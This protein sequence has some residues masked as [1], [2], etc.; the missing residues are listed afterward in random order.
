MKSP[1]L[2]VPFT[3]KHMTDCRKKTESII[4]TAKTIHIFP[5]EHIHHM[6]CF[7]ELVRSDTQKQNMYF[8]TNIYVLLNTARALISVIGSSILHM[9]LT[10]PVSGL[11]TCDKYV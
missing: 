10:V 3:Q 6:Y 8:T 4:F 5:S 7:L 9:I 1:P 11:M 2:K